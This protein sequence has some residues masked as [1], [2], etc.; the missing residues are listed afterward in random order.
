[1]NNIK[2]ISGQKPNLDEALDFYVKIGWG[3][4]SQYD[5]VRFQKA[6]D[7][8]HFIL[9]YDENT[10]VG[11]IRLMSD[12][13]HETNVS[14]FMVMPEYQKNGIGK[15]L[16]ECL[17][18]KYG[19]TDIYISTPKEHEEFFLK[20]GMKSQQSLLQVSRRASS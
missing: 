3:K 4:R 6:F 12:Q 11:M 13:A 14:E 7:F 9:A 20:N 8:S 18:E 1:M 15:K 5:D 10:L 16:L 19:H 2:I 17:Y